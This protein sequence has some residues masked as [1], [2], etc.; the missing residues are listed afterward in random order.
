VAQS[1]WLRGRVDSTL[2]PLGV[3][4]FGSSQSDSSRRE[5]MLDE[6]R[7][8]TCKAW[9][10]ASVWVQ[11]RWTR[12]NNIVTRVGRVLSNVA[13]IVLLCFYVV[14]DDRALRSAN[15]VKVVTHSNKVSDRLIQAYHHHHHHHH[16][17]NLYGAPYRGSA[18]PYNTMSVET[19]KQQEHA[20]TKKTFH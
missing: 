13:D 19:Q 16:H 14:F 20:K 8:T 6:R 1:D 10:V 15:A 12:A 5:S 7:S 2:K 3:A 18:A 11:Q 4:F 17:E 9:L